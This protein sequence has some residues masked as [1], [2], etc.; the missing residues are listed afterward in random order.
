[1]LKRPTPPRFETRKSTIVTSAVD[2]LNRKGIRGMTLGDVA[3]TLDL[4]PTAV[5]Y[6]FKRKEELAATCFLKAIERYNDFISF[7][8]DGA[9]VRERVKRFLQAYFDFKRD[10]ITGSAEPIA[11]FNDVRALNAEPVNVAY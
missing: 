9:T 5:I 10:V 11:V 2:V 1:M 4:V 8:E 3:A 6:Y 7:A